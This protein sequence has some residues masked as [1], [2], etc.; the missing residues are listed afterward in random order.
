[1]KRTTVFLFISVLFCVNLFSQTPQYYNSNTGTGVNTYPWGQAAGQRVHWLIRPGTLTTPSAC[2]GGLITNL[3]FWMGNSGSATFSNM[4]IKLGCLTITTLPTAW[5]TTE[6]DTVYFRSSVSMSCTNSTWMVITLDRP[7]IYDTSKALVIDVQQCS[8][9]GTGLYVRQS[10]GT[11]ATRNYGTPSACPVSYI[12]QDGQIINFGIDVQPLPGTPPYYN[13]MTTGSNNSFPFGISTGKMVQWL[14]PAAAQTGGWNTPT[15]PLSGGMINAIYVWIGG[16]YQLPSTTYNNFEVLMGQTSLTTLTTGQ[17][18]SGPMDTVLYR[19]SYPLQGSLNTWV[20]IVLDHSKPYAPDSGLVLQIGQCN[21]NISLTYPACQTSIGAIHRVWSVGGCPFT[22][23]TTTSDGYVI[24]TGVNIVYPT[25]VSNNNNQVPGTY[26]LE[27]NYPN[28]F[29]PVTIISYS[30]P[31]AGNVKLTVFDILGRE[32]AALVNENKTA[33][34]YNIEF[35]ASNL[36]S[37]V[38]VYKMESGEFIQTKKM[39]L[40][41]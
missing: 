19:A 8:Y 30:I 32:V 34:S 25:G 37:G 23:Y 5:Y 9:T 14:I 31:K 6:L 16:T 18:Y 29:N 22:P 11:P 10:S 39:I 40:I 41:K 13:Y 1:M 15:P 7:F 4:T 21:A 35:D 12:G 33:G 2:P 24:H 17:F 27:Q 28:P 20:R 26:R 38:Y 3:Y 36:A